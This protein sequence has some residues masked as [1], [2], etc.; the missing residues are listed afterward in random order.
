MGDFAG[1]NLTTGDV[2]IDILNPGVAAESNTIRIGV[3]QTRT[4]I[5]GIFGTNAPGSTVV[6]KLGRPTWRGGLLS[7]VQERD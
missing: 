1:G 3:T 6:V 4:F 5:A 7:P 2:N